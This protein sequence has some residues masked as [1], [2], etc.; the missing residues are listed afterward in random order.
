[1]TPEQRAAQVAAAHDAARGRRARPEESAR[2]AITIERQARDGLRKP[3]SG[4][5]LM[6]GWLAEAGL[7]CTFQ[8]AVWRYN[9]DIAIGEHFG[10]EILGGCW[11]AMK[12]RRVK[13]ASR[14]KE[15]LSRGWCVAYVWNTSSM[16]MNR[17]CAEQVVSFYKVASAFPSSRGK[18]WVVRGDGKITAFDSD[19]VNERAFVLPSEARK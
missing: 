14:L 16:P 12:D 3:S 5:S 10:V 17:W 2:R 8:K 1:M 18:Y 11:H 13:E 15:L 4:E 7:E 6:L 19:Y 9:L